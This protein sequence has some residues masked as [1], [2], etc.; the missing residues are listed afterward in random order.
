MKPDFLKCMKGKGHVSKSVSQL[1]V[2]YH[3]RGSTI[4]CSSVLDT[5]NP[6]H[7]SSTVFIGAV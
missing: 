6:T 1:S 7:I 5:Y 2:S 3:R 4:I